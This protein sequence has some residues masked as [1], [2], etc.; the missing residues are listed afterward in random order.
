MLPNVFVSWSDVKKSQRFR[1]QSELN[2]KLKVENP[3]VLTYF[4][5]WAK[6]GAGRQL[7]VCVWGAMGGGNG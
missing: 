6:G 4:T 1:I 2:S 5:G 7:S 3:P